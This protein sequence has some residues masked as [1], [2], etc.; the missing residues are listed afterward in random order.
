MIHLDSKAKLEMNS[1][2]NKKISKRKQVGCIHVF[3]WSYKKI[4]IH[5]KREPYPTAMCVSTR[6]EQARYIIAADSG[7]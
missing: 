5:I 6:F 1:K 4:Y 7:W 3:S 2:K